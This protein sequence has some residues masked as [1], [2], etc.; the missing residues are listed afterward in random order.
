MPNYWSHCQT[1]NRNYNSL[2]SLSECNGCVWRALL[3]NTAVTT[4][5]NIQM[6]RSGPRNIPAVQMP[7]PFSYCQ[8]AGKKIS[9]L[10]TAFF[11]EQLFTKAWNQELHNQPHDDGLASTH[12]FG[13]EDVIGWATDED[14]FIPVPLEPN[15]VGVAFCCLLTR[16]A[17]SRQRGRQTKTTDMICSSFS[18]KRTGKCST[19]N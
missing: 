18:N 1:I 5:C 6:P 19:Q 11:W 9:A 8:Q 4:H 17:D 16:W 7:T 15:L 2:L 14:Q 12:D 10:K 3:A 13:N